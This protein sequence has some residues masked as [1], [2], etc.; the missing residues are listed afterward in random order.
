MRRG[1]FW[2]R[3]GDRKRAERGVLV[4]ALFLFEGAS[5]EGGR[6]RHW[7]GND[8]CSVCQA[9]QE[10]GQTKGRYPRET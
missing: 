10:R 5:F 7:E 1:R 4:D 6:K 9:G 3:G 2:E 8:I